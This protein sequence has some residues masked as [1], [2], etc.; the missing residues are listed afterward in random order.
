MHRS[1]RGSGVR[2]LA[3]RE[4]PAEFPSCPAFGGPD[5]ATLY[6]TSI[7]D[8]GSGRMIGTRPESG[9]VMAITGLGIAGVPEP[10]F[11]GQPP[12]I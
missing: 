4:H 6:V 12:N 11:T 9:K 7:R 1:T 5:L 2:E 3:A 10:R 8:S